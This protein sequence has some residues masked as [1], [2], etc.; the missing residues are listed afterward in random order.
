MLMDDV[1]GEIVLRRLC[2]KDILDSLHRSRS[3]PQRAS[4]SGAIRPSPGRCAIKFSACRCGRRYLVCSSAG[5]AQPA[6]A[7]FDREIRPM[8]RHQPAPWLSHDVSGEALI[9]AA[10]VGILFEN[11]SLR[12]K[13]IIGAI[14]RRRA[15]GF[16]VAKMGISAARGRF[17]ARSP[18]LD[19]CERGQAVPQL[20]TTCPGSHQHLRHCRAR[21][22]GFH[23]MAGRR[24][25]R[26][27]VR[28]RP[29][30]LALLIGR[31]RC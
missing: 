12:A 20:P 7:A 19:Q 18:P 29:L 14:R 27:N 30:V 1:R 4:S 25:G 15:W 3:A 31:A 21:A 23:P 9:L 11:S 28:R 17:P 13:R 22:G 10:L 8:D 24:S 26:L 2:R 16:A 6:G 5:A